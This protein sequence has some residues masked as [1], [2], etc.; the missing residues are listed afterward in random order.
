MLHLHRLKGVL[1]SKNGMTAEIIPNEPGQ[2][3]LPRETTKT[4]SA[5]LAYV[6][7]PIFIF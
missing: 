7:K 4:K 5:R 1:N 2:V 3:M 6:K